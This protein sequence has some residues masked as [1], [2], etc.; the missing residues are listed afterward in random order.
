MGGRVSPAT[1]PL[2]AQ[3]MARA[4]AEVKPTLWSAMP[5]ILE[6]L[7]LA[8]EDGT[9]EV[10][11]EAVRYPKAMLWGAA[12]MPED[13]ARR[14][15]AQGV[16][17]CVTYGQTETCGFVMGGNCG[18]D[19]APTALAPLQPYGCELVDEAG[20]PSKDEGQFIL[21]GCGS[22]FRGYVGR[23]PR[24]EAREARRHRSAGRARPG[25]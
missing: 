20:A 19:A 24:P 12:P 1:R 3:V 16:P 11:A 15:H 17:T 5:I 21:L 14:L 8:L 18:D 13:T 23:E 4:C 9:L 7:A 6:Q 22:T 2:N 25:M 10:P